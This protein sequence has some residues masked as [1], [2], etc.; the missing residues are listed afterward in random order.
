MVPIGIVTRDR[1][2]FLDV[3]LRSLSASQ[4]PLDIAVT[5]FD[6]GSNDPATQRYLYTEAKVSL[7]YEWPMLPFVK[8]IPRHVAG[9]GIAGKI[10]TRRYLQSFGVIRDSCRAILAMCSKYDTS[11]GIIICQDDIIFCQDWYTRLI[12]A[13]A[14]KADA[15]LIAGVWL[16]RM[17]PVAEG[18]QLV[19]AG[20]VSAQVYYVTPAGLEAARDFLRYPPSAMTGFDNKFCAAVRKSASVYVM[21]PGIAQHIGI[22]STVRPEVTWQRWHT[23]GRID[24]TTEGPFSLADEVRYFKCA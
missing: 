23:Y 10:P 14:S 20:G 2:K 19:T 21:T 13:A 5:V 9:A 3:T 6:C 24:P 18:P 17:L 7:E 1:H 4:L 11:S 12:D 22:T 8:D 15:G 16:M